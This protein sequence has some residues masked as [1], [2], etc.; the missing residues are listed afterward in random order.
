MRVTDIQLIPG[1]D[2]CELTGRVE[3]EATPGGNAWFA[4]F[5]LWYRFPTWC[6]PYL[7]EENG[8]P[9]LAALLLPAMMRGERLALPAPISPRLRRRLP[10]LQAIHIS[11]DGRLTRVPVEAPAPGTT[12]PAAAPDATGLFFSLGVDSFYSLLKHEARLFGE[13]E[14]ITHL[15]TLHGMHG[16]TEPSFRPRVLANVERVARETGKRLVPVTTNVRLVADRLARWNMSHGAAVLSVA[17]ALDGLCERVLLAASTTYDQLYP[18]GTHPM[19]DP[20]WSTER[21]EVVHDGAEMDRIGK[22][23]VLAESP[24][25]LDTLRVCPGY[26][27]AYNCGRCVKCLP[28]MIDLFQCGALAR[29]ATFPHE[30]DIA[31]LREIF[32]AYASQLNVENYQRRLDKLDPE[33]SPPGLREALAEFLAH[34]AEAPPS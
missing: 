24:L 7:R 15:I 31:A 32:R 11:F 29:S 17:L 21:L 13:Q 5:S 34:A 12:P 18:W 9:F 10:D 22:V 25:A 4:P 23:G 16:E 2:A 14:R 6:R 30:F 3:S 19:L 28:T 27:G 1:D 26:G 20:L 33:T 8:D